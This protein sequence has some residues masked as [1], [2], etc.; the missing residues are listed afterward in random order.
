MPP[1]LRSA[2]TRLIIDIHKA[3][4]KDLRS[5][6]TAKRDLFTTHLHTTILGSTERYEAFATK[7]FSQPIECASEDVYPTEAE[8][9]A[10]VEA[11]LQEF[12]TAT[13]DDVGLPHNPGSDPLFPADLHAETGPL[14]PEP[15]TL[16]SCL[17]WEWDPVLEIYVLVV[18]RDLVAVIAGAEL[19]PNDETN[20]VRPFPQTA[21][22]SG[23]T[24]IQA[25]VRIV[26]R[27]GDLV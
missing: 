11:R 24:Q 6:S 15:G 10:F 25:N 27:V 13:Y 5:P 18:N 22:D 19:L 21:S 1:I 7:F 12:N 4:L 26:I 23:L 3:S 16:L 9:F 2:T 20:R 17:H 8:S 14:P